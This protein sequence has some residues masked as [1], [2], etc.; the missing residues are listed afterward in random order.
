[1][2]CDANGFPLHF[3]ITAGQVH[4]NTA[5]EDLLN[6]IDAEVTTADGVPVA[7][8]FAIAGD[9]GYRADWID[10]MLDDLEITPVIP[11]KENQDRDAR[12]VEFDVEQ[13]RKRNIIERLIGWLKECRRV[14]SRYEK[15]AI[16]FRGMIK[17]AIVQR[18]LKIA[19]A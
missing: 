8:P 16:N 15:T 11:S 13:Y 9:K 18:Y 3:D 10:E 4:E 19:T 17:M 6:G 2:I 1:M 7:W 5:L 14:F 12:L